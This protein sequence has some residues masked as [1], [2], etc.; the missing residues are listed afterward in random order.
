[1]ALS[2]VRIGDV[3]VYLDLNDG[4]GEQFLGQTNGGCTL[5]FDR[6]FTDLMVDKYTSPVDMA[7]TGN[8]LKITCNLAEPTTKNVHYAQMEGL[9]AAA[10]T[11]AKTGFGKDAGLLLSTVAG[12][13]RLHP[14]KNTPS[15]RDEDIYIFKAVSTD[16]VELNYKK[17]EQRVL[18]VTFR[19][20]IDESQPNGQR[21]G[22]I[23]DN[24][25]S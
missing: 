3:E 23:G 14:R 12:I 9:Y 18:A 15:S 8:D 5:T 21:L 20:L 25:I 7:L 19:A 1:M 16:T 22:R 2:D 6:E 13:L 17:D 10:G 11:D 24:A 4:A